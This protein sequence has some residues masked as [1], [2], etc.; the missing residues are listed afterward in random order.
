MDKLR[1]KFFLLIDLNVLLSSGFAVV[2]NL[3][4]SLTMFISFNW[5]LGT[6]IPNPS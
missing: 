6:K 2:K 3:I 4:T 5:E 1:G